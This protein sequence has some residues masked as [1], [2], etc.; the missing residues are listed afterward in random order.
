MYAIRSYYGIL[1][2]ARESLLISAVISTNARLQGVSVG[3]REMFEDMTRAIE[4]DHIEPVVDK[5]FPWQDARAALEAME[6][7]EHFGKIVLE[8]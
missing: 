1:S 2:G 8:F 6:R 5:V 4:S 7:G 3:S